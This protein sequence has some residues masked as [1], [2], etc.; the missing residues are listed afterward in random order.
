VYPWKGA[1]QGTTMSGG[2]PR[3]ESDQNAISGGGRTQAAQPSPLVRL[4]SLLG[5][6]AARQ[7]R[8]STTAGG[9]ADP[10]AVQG[11]PAANDDD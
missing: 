2:H 8:M 4:A 6:D 1:Q 3:N 10:E 7:W 11:R 5:R 9:E